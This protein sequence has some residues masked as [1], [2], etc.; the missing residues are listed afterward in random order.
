MS[1][2]QVVSIPKDLQDQLSAI[3]ALAA[4]HDLISKGS[5]NVSKLAQVEQSILFLQ[6]LHKQCMDQA[7]SHP[8]ADQVPELVEVLAA[9]SK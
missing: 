5:F 8:S 1:D 3:R 9:R 4:T 2:E 7:L 6:S